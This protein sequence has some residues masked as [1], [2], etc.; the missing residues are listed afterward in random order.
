[1]PR[2]GERKPI[3]AGSRLTLARKLRGMSQTELAKSVGVTPRAISKYEKAGEGLSSAKLA[4]IAS[5][6]R[7]EPSYFN[8]SDIS[9][10]QEAAISFRARSKMSAKKRDQAIAASAF[11]AVFS[12]WMDSEF[13]LPPAEI[14]D[15]AG[16][17]PEIAASALRAEWGLGDGPVSDVIAQLESHGVRVFSVTEASQ[18]ID[19]YSFWDESRNRPFVFLTTSKSGERRRMD[20]A[21]ELGHLVLHRKVDLTD[22]SS[23]EIESEANAFA[24]AFLMPNRGFRSTVSRNVTLSEVMDVKQIWKTSA[25]AVVVRCHSLGLL[26]DWQ[27]HTL[28]VDM[29]K[30]GMRTNEPNGIIPERSQVNDKIIAIMKKSPEGLAGIVSDTGIPYSILMSLT[31]N[32]S[33]EVIQGGV[34]SRKAFGSGGRKASVDFKVIIH[35]R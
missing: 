31:F 10:P 33:V 27:Y 24:S 19:A 12:D 25:F 7:F 23:R 2:L 30:K 21:H 14:P 8:G 16:Y 29:G 26:S 17:E 1:M 5:V 9:S 13:V 28:C 15:Y 22:R 34:S 3:V 4:E 35:H 11:G 6:L 32:T 18:E 20:A